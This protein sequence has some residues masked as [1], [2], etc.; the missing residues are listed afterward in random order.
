M[1]NAEETRV[2]RPRAGT[3]PQRDMRVLL[4]GA[5]GSGKG[6]QA[7]RVADHFGLTHISSGDL[8]LVIQMQD[9]TINSTNS[10]SYGAGPVP[11]NGSGSTAL[12]F[13]GKYE[14][15]RCINGSPVTAAAGSSR[16]SAGSAETWPL[17]QIAV[18]RPGPA[19]ARGHV[20][21]IL[22]RYLGRN[23]GTGDTR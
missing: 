11:G 4:I 2:P 16:S 22:P 9:A 12:N 13:S 21:A 8:L 15:V 18:R 20:L 17:A 3:R 6:T 23:G 14:Y 10:T 7:G 19:I 1:A 5:P